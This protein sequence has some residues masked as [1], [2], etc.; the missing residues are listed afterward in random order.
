MPPGD[1]PRSGLRAIGRRRPADGAGSQTLEIPFLKETGF[2]F[3][4]HSGD[5]RLCTFP[6]SDVS[7]VSGSLW[8]GDG[9]AHVRPQ[10]YM[11]L[12]TGPHEDAVIYC[13]VS[14]ILSADTKYRTQRSGGTHMPCLDQQ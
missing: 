1:A 7:D 2:L 3:V 6:V 11:F 4:R 5:K 13:A 9:V 8:W 14:S 10:D 12:P